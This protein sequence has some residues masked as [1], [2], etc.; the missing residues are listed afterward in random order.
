MAAGSTHARKL[1]SGI[2]DWT[3]T[4]LITTDVASDIETSGKLARGDMSD[5]TRRRCEYPSSSL[6]ILDGHVIERKLTPWNG[7]EMSRLGNRAVGFSG[8]Q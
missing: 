3:E 6:A 7:Y 5:A 1:H 4:V 2:G 8:G